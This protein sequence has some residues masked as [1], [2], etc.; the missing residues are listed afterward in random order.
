MTFIQR[1]IELAHL[2]S[3]RD[4]KKDPHT[5][6][7]Y[8]NLLIHLYYIYVCVY[9]RVLS[10]GYYFITKKSSGSESSIYTNNLAIDV[11][12]SRKAKECHQ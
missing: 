7:V 6:E 8:I 5:Y 10:M 12:S 3:P 2:I 9:I 4:L 11:R 1:A